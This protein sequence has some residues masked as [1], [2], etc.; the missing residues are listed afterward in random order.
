MIRLNGYEE[1]ASDPEKLSRD[2]IYANNWART[3]A[4]ESYGLGVREELPSE[5]A[6]LDA[7]QRCFLAVIS[8]RLEEGMD[9]DAV[10]NLLYS[11]AIELGLKPKAAF[12]AVYTVLLGK[13]SGPKAGPFIAGLDTDFV[14]E[15]FLGAS[16]DT[17]AGE[18]ES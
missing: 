1:A 16:G 18:A 12:G 11:T 10:Q 17:T 7:E 8:G 13:K 2:L 9:G 5:A 4:P 15:R 3:W 6:G 14:R